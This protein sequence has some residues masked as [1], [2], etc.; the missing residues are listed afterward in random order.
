MGGPG[1]QG[2][3]RCHFHPSHYF[4][5]VISVWKLVTVNMHIFVL[6]IVVLFLFFR[7]EGQLC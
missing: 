6:L 7:V 5:N 3:P 4:P 1:Y 2:I